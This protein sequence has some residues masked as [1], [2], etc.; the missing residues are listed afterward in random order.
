MLHQRPVGAVE[1]GAANI[2][3]ATLTDKRALAF[4]GRRYSAMALAGV[5]A[6]LTGAGFFAVK[7]IGSAEATYGTAYGFMTGAKAALFLASDLASAV[8]GIVLN[9]DCGEFHDN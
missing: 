4:I 2:A 3:R 9:V 7:Y 5:F 6:L 1:V 8:T